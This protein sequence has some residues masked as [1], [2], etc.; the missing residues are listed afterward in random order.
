MYFMNCNSGSGQRSGD[1]TSVVPAGERQF[2]SYYFQNIARTSEGVVDTMTT[3]GDPDKPYAWTW[4]EL[5]FRGNTCEVRTFRIFT[6]RTHA[7]AQYPGH[8]VSKL[9]DRQY[10]YR[11]TGS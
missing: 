3:A 6:R 9:I 1:T 8:L 10:L 4:Q 7:N 5:L 2:K 11:R